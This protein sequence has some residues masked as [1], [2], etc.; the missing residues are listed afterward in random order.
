MAVE[1]LE[2]G[3]KQTATQAH[4]NCV[5]CSSSNVNG[6]RLDFNVSDAGGVTATFDC[7]PQFEGYAGRLHGGIVASLLDSAMTNCLFANACS[8]VTLRL[9]VRYR[10]PVH[11]HKPATVRACVERSS[12]PRHVLKAEVVQDGEVKATAEGRF[13]EQPLHLPPENAIQGAD[14]GPKIKS[15]MQPL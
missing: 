8:A 6:L 2:A 10:H 1:Y 11:T 5:L 7:D 14:C 4:P 9:T 15:P 13:L 3:L 12:P